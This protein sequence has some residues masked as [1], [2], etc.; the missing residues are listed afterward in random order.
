MRGLEDLP[1]VFSQ[2]SATLRG[3]RA[4]YRLLV[5]ALVLEQLLKLL[6]V[7]LI[8]LILLLLPLLRLRLV[9]VMLL[10]FTPTQ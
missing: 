8:R 9:L 10:C 7:L 4:D 3:W 5:L 6:L 1:D 2:P